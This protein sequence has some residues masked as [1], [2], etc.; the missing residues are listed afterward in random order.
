MNI[1]RRDDSSF[2]ELSYA[3]LAESR[4][5]RLWS[6]VARHRFNPRGSTRGITRVP[7][8]SSPVKP[9]DSKRRRAPHSMVEWTTR[10]SSLH[11]ILR[12]RRVGGGLE[13]ACSE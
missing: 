10:R 2:E 1:G 4:P 7:A 3:C 13:L 5:A 9:A 11:C 8:Q 6:A 12:L